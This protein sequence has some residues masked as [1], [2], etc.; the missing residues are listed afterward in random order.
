MISAKPTYATQTLPPVQIVPETVL[1]MTTAPKNKITLTFEPATPSIAASSPQT[2]EDAASHLRNRRGSGF[3]FSVEASEEEQDVVQI[4]QSPSTSSA[5]TRVIRQLTDPSFLE[6]FDDARAVCIHP[7]AS[8]TQTG[9]FAS[10]RAVRRLTDPSIKPIADESEDSTS[11][12]SDESKDDSD[13]GPD[14]VGVSRFQT[15]REE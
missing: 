13:Q 10:T 14:G 7:S 11:R 8:S 6:S 4:E 9:S 15:A 1:D 5:S 2:T 12:G 3:P